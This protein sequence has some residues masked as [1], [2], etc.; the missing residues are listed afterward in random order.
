MSGEIHIGDNIYQSGAASIGKIQYQ[1]SPDS[2]AALREM[3]N[4]AMELATQVNA[5]DRE[6]IN[7]SAQVAR[8]AERAER[9]ALR[10]ALA[11]LIGVATMAGTAGS[12]MLDAALKVKELFG[13]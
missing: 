2:Q 5:T 6:A 3:I 4:L 1:G 10:R 12:P 11:N 9:G 8:Q 13:L 7:E